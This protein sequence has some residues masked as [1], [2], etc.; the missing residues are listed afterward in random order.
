MHAL[1]RHGPRPARDAGD[2]PGILL[3]S[4]RRYDFQVWL[5][6]RGREPW[7]RETILKKARLNSGETVL[8]IGCGTGTLALTAGRQIGSGEVHGVD[9]SPE[10]IAAARAKALRDRLDV[11]FETAT[12]QA[13]PF[14]DG[15]FDLVT[16]T[17]MLHHLTRPIRQACLSEVLRVLKPGGRALVVD[18]A[19]SSQTQGGFLRQL[20]HHGRVRPEQIAALLSDAGLEVVDSGPLGLRDLH[21]VLGVKPGAPP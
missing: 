20:H 17:L 6:T 9:A 1:F 13:L 8:D 5:A 7:L 11:H 21:Y 10:M 18:F 4:P 16:S 15:R 14:A 12:A 3:H 19:T 2:A